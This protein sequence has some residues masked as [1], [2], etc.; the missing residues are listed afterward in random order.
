LSKLNDDVTPPKVER[1]ANPRKRVVLGAVVAIDKGNISFKCRI[2]DISSDG[3]RI[4]I[5]EGQPLPSELYLINLRDKLAHRAHVM[6]I[7]ENEAG[8]VLFSTIDLSTSNDPEAEFLRRI[9]NNNSIP[10]SGN[11]GS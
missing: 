8:L 2:R 11:I 1:R 5:A 3:A 9:W 10:I 4:L 7:R 6:W